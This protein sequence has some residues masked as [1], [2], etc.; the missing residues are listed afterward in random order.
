MKTEEIL[1]KAQKEKKMSI[2]D[3]WGILLLR[4]WGRF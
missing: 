3:M 4:P 2:S 1:A